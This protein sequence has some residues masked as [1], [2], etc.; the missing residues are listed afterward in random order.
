MHGLTLH[1]SSLFSLDGL[2]AATVTHRI[3]SDPDGT[4][5][6][7]DAFL[8]ERVAA[9][10]AVVRVAS[11]IGNIVWKQLMAL[12]SAKPSAGRRPEGFFAL[13]VVKCGAKSP[14]PRGRAII[15]PGLSVDTLAS[16]T[17]TYAPAGLLLR[18][19]LSKCHHQPPCDQFVRRIMDQLQPTSGTVVG[20]NSLDID[21]FNPVHADNE[22]TKVLQANL[23]VY[24]LTSRRGAPAFIAWHCTG[25]GFMT[26]DF[27]NSHEMLFSGPH[28]CI[29]TFTNADNRGE[30]CTN[31]KI[32]GNAPCSWMDLK[33][34]GRFTVEE[35]FTPMFSKTIQ[36]SWI[37][38]LGN[39]ANKDPASYTGPLHTW[40]TMV[41]WIM[42]LNIN[43][44]KDY[45]LTVLQM[46]NNAAILGVI[47]SFAH[48][49]L[50]HVTQGLETD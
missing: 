48:F 27:A 19:V 21:H 15:D 7:L 30:K 35:K 13:C 12:G 26:R 47:V 22:N 44:L 20:K 46:A 39:L 17:L 9:S 23:P 37:K 14:L 38:F 45:S 34:E 43:C 32:W 50:E 8:E 4:F 6:T 42:D 1:P 49:T 29:S 41:V 10:P 24:G 3:L 18:E 16:D 5:S 25:Q 2:K 40:W 28:A 11:D 36:D 31:T 33:I